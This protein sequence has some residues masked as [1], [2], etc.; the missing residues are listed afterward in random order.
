MMFVRHSRWI[1]TVALAA[2]SAALLPACQDLLVEPAA[3]ATGGLAIAFVASASSAAG[4]AEAFDAADAAHV[5]VTGAGG[6]VLID[7]VF[8]LPAPGAQRRV[9]VDVSLDADAE[10]LQVDASLLFSG[11]PVFQGTTSVRLERGQTATA[12]ITLAAIAAGIEVAAPSGPITAIGNTLALDG[13]AVFATGDAVDGV[14]LD[15]E[16]LDP[17]VATVSAQG[18][19][20]AH[21]EGD[22][23]IVA[24]H[25]GH[26][27]TVV[28]RVDPLATRIAL[29]PTSLLLGVGDGRMVAAT[30]YDA[31]DNVL[32]RRPSWRS[33]APSIA[34]VVDTAGFVRGVA[35]GEAT[36]TATVGSASAD[37]AVTV[38][39]P[40]GPVISNLRT[41][42]APSTCGLSDGQQA[43][44]IR[45]TFDYFDANGDVPNPVMLTYDWSYQPSGRDST[46]FRVRPTSGSGSTG[47]VT[48]GFC[49][50]FG[51]DTELTEVFRITDA[52]GRV[53][54]D[55]SS[56]TPKPDSSSSADPG[57]SSG[58]SAVAPQQSVVRSPIA[59]SSPNPHVEGWTTEVKDAATPPP[60]ADESVVGRLRAVGASRAQSARSAVMGSTPAARRA[61]SQLA[62]KP[63][64]RRTAPTAAK[65]SGSVGAMPKRTARR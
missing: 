7:D 48:F 14:S 42:V 36:I 18:V 33:S 60:G 61:G 24:S 13:A 38:T 8:A 58:V 59:T 56:V 17:T 21:A 63:T 10:T 15:W 65:V 23:R 53:S 39:T 43:T 34:T 62:N 44:S 19:V 31:N 55:L 26:E 22:A 35:E 49:H 46:Y 3:P 1:R 4:D 51:T 52:S 28:V 32:N 57:V 30:V 64:A 9:E 11:E 40:V 27:T 47:S 5:H 6:N 25:L 50:F 12:S 2:A 54:N 16:S 41:E 37:V 20:T 29:D 45:H